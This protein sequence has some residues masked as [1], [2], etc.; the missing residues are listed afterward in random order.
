[1]PTAASLCPGAGRRMRAAGRFLRGGEGF[2]VA[3][4]QTGKNPVSPGPCFRPDQARQCILPSMLGRFCAPAFSAVHARRGEP[5]S[6]GPRAPRGR[7]AFRGPLCL[8]G[9]RDG[10]SRR[11]PLRE[12]RQPRQ[13][14]K[15]AAGAGKDARQGVAGRCQ[16][17]PAEERGNRRGDPG[18]GWV[19]RGALRR[20]LCFRHIAAGKPRELSF[21][22]GR[23][24]G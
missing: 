8:A 2:F 17:R 9:I 7:E 22:G 21:W 20:S 23:P 18:T 13:A 16:G 11:N 4:K 12:G 3:L 10:A 1:M 6:S 5:H 14:P 15:A 19:A 24:A